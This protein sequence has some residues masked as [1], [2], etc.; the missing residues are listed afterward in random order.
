MLVAPGCGNRE[1]ET[2]RSQPSSAAAE[3]TLELSEPD[4]ILFKPDF[5]HE[6]S[7]V[8]EVGRLSDGRFVVA[9]LNQPLLLFDQ[10]GRFLQPVGGGGAGPAE[11]STNY[12][13]ALGP[14]DGIYV[15][16]A[17]QMRLVRFG[18]DLEYRDT[19]V[20]D[21]SS[22]RSF[23]VDS[24]ERIY[25]LNEDVFG[26]ETSAVVVYDTSLAV[27]DRWGTLPPEALLQSHIEG[28]GL[29]IDESGRAVV[30]GYMTDPRL[31]VVTLSDK[32]LSTLDSTPDYFIEPSA[33][34]VSRLRRIAPSDRAREINQYSATVSWV[35]SLHLTSNGYLFQQILER[36]RGDNPLG[37][38]LEVW[39]TR[40]G[41]KIATRVRYG[42]FD[43]LHADDQSLYFLR[44]ISSDSGYYGLN[45]V[46]YTI[47]CNA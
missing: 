35:R 12:Q 7:Y 32:S 33:S 5:S 42:S 15:I 22:V 34:S 37:L 18:P 29:E 47:Q 41:T 28:G 26:D 44:D 38:F 16:D 17:M 23:T 1:R 25:I 4:S 45:V 14:D 19:R 13:F 6:I 24:D 43:L 46:D 39:D 8:K 10:E 27:V 21:K 9:S 3:C 11:Y 36:P 40:T 2:G 31:Y 20:L 30:Y